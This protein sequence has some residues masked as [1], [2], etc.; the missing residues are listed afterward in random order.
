MDWVTELI[1]FAESPEK[2]LRVTTQIEDGIWMPFYVWV[3]V[4]VTLKKWFRILNRINEL[5][6]HLESRSLRQVKNNWFGNLKLTI[7]KFTNFFFVPFLCAEMRFECPE[8]ET[9]NV[10]FTIS[11]KKK[12]V[13]WIMVQKLFLS[14]KKFRH[15]FC[16][17]L[18]ERM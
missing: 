16:L 8:L 12:I 18:R 4:W 5:S 10:S 13:Y 2:V 17:F 6:A 14:L 3:T 11:E 7:Y 1:G 9:K 15:C